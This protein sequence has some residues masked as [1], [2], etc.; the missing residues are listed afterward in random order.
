M[1]S[2]WNYCRN[3]DLV[4]SLTTPW[5]P[6]RPFSLK[7]DA[8]CQRRLTGL[9][10]GVGGRV[11]VGSG[12]PLSSE[13]GPWGGRCQACPEGTW[14]FWPRLLGNLWNPRGSLFAKS[15]CMCVGWS[16]Q[17]SHSQSCLGSH[18]PVCPR[19]W[20]CCCAH[21]AALVP[22]VLPRALVPQGRW[23]RLRVPAGS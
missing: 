22:H 6:P 13:P 23:L 18:C 7:C 21:V 10:A 14:C 4:I 11:G 9:G 1:L 15:R 20:P 5:P 16:L 19:V 12:A 17:L 3:T 8:C 2:F